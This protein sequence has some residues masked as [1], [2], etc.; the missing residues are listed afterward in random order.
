[1]SMK[2]TLT[3]SGIEPA[4]FWFVAQYFNHNATGF[5]TYER[6]LNII[7]FFYA[8]GE[9]AEI[10]ALHRK[11]GLQTPKRTDWVTSP[12]TRQKESE[13]CDEFRITA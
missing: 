3:P 7:R 10:S 9:K 2:N 4:T 8:A 6:R 5:P 1:M 12:Y 13:K 11:C